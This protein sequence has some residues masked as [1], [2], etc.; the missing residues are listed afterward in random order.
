LLFSVPLVG[1]I[2]G[3][4]LSS[5]LQSRFGRKWALVYAY[6][7]SIGGV[8]L[9]LFAPTLGAFVAG[10]FWNAMSYGAATA[11]APLYLGDIVPPNIRGATVQASSIAAIG[12]G[13][14]A[15]LI[16]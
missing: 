13:V 8:L 3:A 12:S 7:F 2:F 11:I 5:P 6:A 14:I 16:I 10:R 15:N 4:I 1:S 9:Q